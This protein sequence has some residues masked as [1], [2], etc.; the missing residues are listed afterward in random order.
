MSAWSEGQSTRVIPEE[1]GWG[2]LLYN[3]GE[4]ELF[5]HLPLPYANLQPQFAVRGM[6]GECDESLG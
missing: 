4:D 5:R 3:H 6:W 1:L 2:E